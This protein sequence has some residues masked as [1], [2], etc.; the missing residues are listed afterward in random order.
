MRLRTGIAV[1]ALAA[2]LGVAGE[3]N[4][5]LKERVR[6]TEEAFAKTMA[7][8]D[9]AAFA[10]HLS[11]EAVF[12]GAT[13][14]TRGKDAV[15]SAWKPFFEGPE[16]PFSWAPEDVEVLDSGTLALSSGPVLDSKGYRVGTFTSV[17]RRERDGAWRIVLD[18][19]C[20]PCDC[21]EAEVDP[22]AKP[23]DER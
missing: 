11:D 6:R 13:S 10:S 2:S 22:A 18:K 1:F 17:W 19:G 4:G 23:P 14:V 15:A 5:A 8:R 9:H 3:S 7:D 20:P 21:G 12:F 16:A